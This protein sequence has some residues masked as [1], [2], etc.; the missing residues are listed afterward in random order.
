MVLEVVPRAFV[1]LD[2]RI[3]LPV[4]LCQMSVDVDLAA[5]LGRAAGAA[6]DGLGAVMNP[7][8][9]KEMSPVQGFQSKVDWFRATNLSR[10]SRA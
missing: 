9:V 2:R 5:V 6:E 7:P 1:A 10:N 8:V 3:Q 4:H